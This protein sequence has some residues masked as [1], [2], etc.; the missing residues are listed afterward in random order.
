MQPNE[1]INYLQEVC[2]NNVELNMNLKPNDLDST[3]A[4]DSFLEAL[5]FVIS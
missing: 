3:D 4:L 1:I 2:R 5:T